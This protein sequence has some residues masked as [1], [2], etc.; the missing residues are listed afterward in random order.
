L[1]TRSSTLDIAQDSRQ[2]ESKS[3]FGQTA[4]KAAT[5]MKFHWILCLLIQSLALQLHLTEAF[6]SI[7]PPRHL[8]VELNPFL[9]FPRHRQR[10]LVRSI[11]PNDPLFAKAV[12][13]SGSTPTSNRQL[14]TN[15]P[16]CAMGGGNVD[17]VNEDVAQTM[18]Y[19]NRALDYFLSTCASVSEQYGT[20][21]STRIQIVSRGA[22]LPSLD[23][24]VISIKS[25]LFV[26]SS[27]S[28]KDPMIVIL[29]EED[30]VDVSKVNKI[31]AV[32]VELAAANQIQSLCGFAPGTVPPLGHSSTPLSTRPLRTY[33]DQR[34]VDRTRGTTKPPILLGNGGHAYW[35][36]L[37]PL[38]T[39]LLLD[40]VQSADLVVDNANNRKNEDTEQKQITTLSSASSLFAELQPK[41]IFPVAPP[42]LHV[43]RLVLDQRDLS[44]PLLPTMVTIVGRV[45]EIQP[46]GKRIV[47]CALLPPSMNSRRRKKDKNR[48]SN[49]DEGSE[50]SLV[51]RRPWRFGNVDGTM[52]DMAVQLIAGKALSERL[53]QG[54]GE[55]AVESLKEGQL[56]LVEAKTNV[57]NRES[58]GN[59]VSKQS[60]DLVMV[61]YQI[62]EEGECDENKRQPI[63]GSWANPAEKSSSSKQFALPLLT[64]KDI[65]VFQPTTPAPSTTTASSLPHAAILVDNMVSIQRFAKD[66]ANHMQSLTTGDTVSTDDET[67]DSGPNVDLVGID[68]EWKPDTIVSSRREPR[69]VLVLQVSIH[70]M[71]QV[72]IFDLMTLLRPMLSVEEPM[73]EV[74]KALS[75]ILGE[76]WLSPQMVKCGYQVSSDL[77]LIAASYP[78]VPCFREVNAVLEVSTLIKKALHVTKQKKSRAITMSLAKLSEHYLGKT[79]DKEQQLSDWSARPL[80]PVQMEYASLDAA[81]APA[82]VEKT[83]ESIAASIKIMGGDKQPR[84]ERWT[85][86]SSFTKSIQSERFL[87]LPNPADPNLIEKVDAKQI[88]GPSWIAAQDWI[89]GDEPPPLPF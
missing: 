49:D 27:T 82:L 7:Q 72:Y 86:D 46:M 2:K 69:P 24:P 6:W 59:W 73:N 85:D 52:T 60:L 68:C 22:K 51:D 47:H 5:T 18:E 63:E 44:N 61:E 81:I 76:L 87:C 9:E 83:L 43:A 64:M 75:E 25:L 67:K 84:I 15:D 58:L 54:Q 79:L 19:P 56:I 41:P 80:L 12:T 53:G 17:D 42:P 28:L 34:L 55:V 40:H 65:F 8:T 4:K 20:S 31:A 13:T 39:L 89:T 36:C 16:S 45:G 26:T 11:P 32:A 10:S 66:Y 29:A 14:D 77:R 23:H 38:E 33:V 62:L 3:E 74:E 50:T 30:Q 70:S 48:M 78:H 37:V 88:M 35:Q 21:S 1:E 57:G 71:Q